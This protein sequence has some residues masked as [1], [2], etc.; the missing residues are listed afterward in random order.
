M[1]ND[2][3]TF[4]GDPAADVMSQAE[5]ADL[6]FVSRMVGFSTGTALTPQLNKVWRQASLI[7][8]MIGQFSTDHAG[9]DMLDDATAAGMAAL[10]AT[11]TAA[12]TQVARSSVGGDYLPLAGGTLTGPLRIDAPTL[13]VTAPGGQWATLELS[14]QAG[15]GAQLIGA[16]GVAARFS[17]AL[18]D[19][20]PELGANQGSNFTIGRF[21]DAGGYLGTP[22]SINRASG[23]V[24]FEVPP[25]VG[26]G[27]MPYLPIAGGTLLGA[28]GVGG[29]GIS[30]PGIG[31]NHH[32][33]FGWQGG[34]LDF[35]VDGG[36]QGQLATVAW[37]Q[38]LVGAY[39]PLAG[40]TI[41]GG[42]TVNGAATF[43]SSVAFGNAADFA[44]FIS[45]N[46]R[47]RQWA[48]NW[49]DY[50]DGSNGTRVWIGP[51]GE[52]MQL[53]GAG[54]MQVF[55]EFRARTGRVISE[56]SA[57][58]GSTPSM[59]MMT[60]GGYPAGMWANS[61]GL[62]LG[63]SDAAGNP[64]NWAML[65][66]ASPTGL[67]LM[68]GSLYVYGSIGQGSDASLK[69]NISLADDF[70]SLLSIC[71]TPLVSYDRIGDEQHVA[72]GFLASHLRRTLPD[73]VTKVRAP[74][75]RDL[76]SVDP[77]ALIAHCFRA[78]HQLHDK[79]L[80]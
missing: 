62:W 77:M 15:M 7:A 66:P 60:D 61:Q 2:F 54:N 80:G 74:D 69:L 19:Q 26:G 39:L 29:I 59:V 37:A 68:Q 58:S 50:W 73:A 12:V 3:L 8:S 35:A 43:R 47:I 44:N 13:T 71:E 46:G 38:G 6:A 64:G 67:A 42:L 24:N 51:S 17:V 20:E 56:A 11:F 10:Q 25:T 53:D 45:G 52:L 33:A 22:L 65:L 18:A 72:H 57:A 55:G 40:G 79:L 78:I 49:Y 76:D 5:Y 9:T 36:Y 21:S 70:D 23:V 27:L 75:G 28:L 16:T 1:A 41:T 30:Y 32:I 34:Y 48:G 14:R 4:A 31:W 63:I